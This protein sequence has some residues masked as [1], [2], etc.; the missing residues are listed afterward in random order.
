MIDIVCLKWGDKF[1]PEYVNNLFSGIERNSTVPF[2]F[3]CFTDDTTGVLENIQCHKLPELDITGW[4][5][6]LWL[7]SDEM[8]FE[9]GTRIMFFDL[10]T[11]VTGNID[12]ILEYDCPKDLTG[13]KNFY[14]PD[15]FASGLLMWKHG[16]QTDIWTEFLKSPRKAQAQ[17]PGGDQ[18]WT[19]FCA[20]GWTLWQE[21]FSGIYSYK[22][23]CSQGLPPNAK[24]VCY[25]GTPSIIQSFTETVENWDSKNRNG[26]IPY[27]PQAWVTDHW[28]TNIRN[29]ARG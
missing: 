24:I 22:Q 23:S 1:G 21:E 8:P 26:G 27:Y 18:E 25:H 6:K 12:D 16:T 11:I 4:W 3:H 10:D 29:N 20:E 13:L 28:R 9:P 14:N 5:Y 2:K 17:S 19:E 15:R 7:F